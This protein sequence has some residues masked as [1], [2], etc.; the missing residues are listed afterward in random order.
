MHLADHPTLSR[1]L[2]ESEQRFRLLVQAVRDYAIYM[3]DVDG[4]VTNWNT[5]AE[6]IKGYKEQEIVG[7]HFSRFYTEEDCARGEPTR[8][9]A[10]ALSEGK[11]EKEA[12]RVR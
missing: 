3:L 8:A 2:Y 11:Y 6:A 10:V 1:E 12:Q 5:G 7:Q 9:L 4:R